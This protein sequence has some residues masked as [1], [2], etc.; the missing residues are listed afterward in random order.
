MSKY[1]V[2]FIFYFIADCFLKT[3]EQHMEWGIFFVVL[4]T[5]IIAEIIEKNGSKRTPTDI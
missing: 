2:L 3:H 1:T 5:G 4:F